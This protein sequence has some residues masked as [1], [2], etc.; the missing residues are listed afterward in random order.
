MSASRAT[1]MPRINIPRTPQP[2]PMVV[3][4]LP[5]PRIGKMGLPSRVGYVP[6]AMRTAEPAIQGFK[7]RGSPSPRIESYATQPQYRRYGG[8]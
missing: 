3:R 2:R 5:A 7:M 8:R 1:P 4:Q 6:E